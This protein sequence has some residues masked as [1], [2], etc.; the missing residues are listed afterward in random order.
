M[1][2]FK[3]NSFKFMS[4]ISFISINK[5]SQAVYNYKG[6]NNFKLAYVHIIYK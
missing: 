6:I 5:K 4:G 1:T 2:T 3:Y